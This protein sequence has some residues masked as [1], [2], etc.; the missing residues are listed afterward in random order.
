MSLSQLVE[1]ELFVELHVV[2]YTL[3]YGLPL[4]DLPKE[5]SDPRYVST[6]ESIKS[7]LYHDL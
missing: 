7:K 4:S 1:V 2:R 5:G 6:D 3:Y